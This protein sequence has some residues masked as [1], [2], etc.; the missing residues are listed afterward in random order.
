M[1]QSVIGCLIVAMMLTGCGKTITEGEIYH[2][3]Y[4][5]AGIAT[6]I[7]Y[8]P[9]YTGKT[10]ITVSVAYTYSYPERY[11]VYIRA[12]KDGELKTEDYYVSAATYD[13]LEVGDMFS[14]DDKRGDMSDEPCTIT[15]NKE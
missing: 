5:P 8:T 12:E 14:F 13:A 9:V 11:V 15:N 10:V 2:M 1:R 3:E 6:Q 4:R 7:M